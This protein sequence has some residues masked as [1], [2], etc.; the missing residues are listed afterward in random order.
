MISSSII[1][2]CL[3]HIGRALIA[4]VMIGA[5]SGC[6]R[7]GSALG[8]TGE[9]EQVPPQPVAAERLRITIVKAGTQATLA[10]VSQR[11]DVTVW[12]TLDGITLSFQDGILIATRGLG[13][14]L[15]ASD[16]D[17]TRDMLRGN[18]T[19]EYYPQIRSYL[20]GEDQIQ[21]R[22]FQCRRS[23]L[24]R[25]QVRLGEVSRSLTRISEHCVSPGRDVTNTFW[26]DT[27]GTVVKS[28]QW[29]RPNVGYVETERVQE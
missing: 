22:S 6:D 14:D 1:T 19:Q 8:L 24:T 2:S 4:F 7:I 11:G 10:P 20:D 17:A 23:G 13:D 3:P 9:V 29:V 27:A 28:R 15:M 5:S 26:I 18:V 25:E 21:F 16:V 12:Q